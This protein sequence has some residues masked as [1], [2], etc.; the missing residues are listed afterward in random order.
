MDFYD[1]TRVWY[2]QW[3]ELFP[4]KVACRVAGIS[5]RKLDHWVTMGLVTP[6]SVYQGPNGRRDF[7]LFAFEQLVQLRIV[8][9][10]RQTGVS[11]QRIR[12]ALEALV[13]EVGSEWHALWLFSDG[14]DVHVLRHSEAIEALTGPRRGQ[15]AFSLVALGAASNEVRGVL[16]KMADSTFDLSRYRGTLSRYG[17][18]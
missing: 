4:A 15:L 11:L 9:A 3:V 7:F 13:R 8:S 1:T 16:L 14:V 6:H 10:L 17:A 12:L 5:A 18:G 2:H